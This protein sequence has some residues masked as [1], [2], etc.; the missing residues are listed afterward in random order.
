[1]PEEEEFD[2]WEDEY[3]EPPQAARSLMEFWHNC[4]ERRYR[5][6]RI[7]AELD[8]LDVELEREEAI[9]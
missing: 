5:E 8:R 2:M 6:E 3:V 4:I 1:M 9:S 7:L